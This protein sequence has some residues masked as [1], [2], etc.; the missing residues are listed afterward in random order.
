MHRSGT[1]LVTQLVNILGVDLGPESEMIRAGEENPRGF[2]ENSHIKSLNEEVLTT[3]GGSW[4]DPPNLDHGWESSENLHDLRLQACELLKRLEGDTPF[5]WKDPR[6]SLTLPFWRTVTNVEKVVVVVRDPSDVATSLKVRNGFSLSKSE[7]LWKWY[8]V[9][10]LVTAP[11]HEL[12]RYEDVLARPDETAVRLADYLGLP[13]PT[14]DVLV[15]VRELVDVQLDRAKA[16]PAERESIRVA[17]GLYDL[18]SLAPKKTY[19]AVCA[20]I[21]SGRVDQCRIQK[22]ECSAK[23]L[24]H[25]RERF[26]GEVVALQRQYA[27]LAHER[28]ELEK[29]KESLKMEGRRLEEERERLAG[30]RDQLRKALTAVANEKEAL[31]TR[32]RQAATERDNYRKKAGQ[33]ERLR[34]RR[35]VRAALFTANAAR[36]AFQVVR[37]VRDS[38]QGNV[39]GGQRSR[40][41]DS[42][43]WINLTRARKITHADV[44]RGEGYKRRCFN[45]SASDQTEQNV[46]NHAN[47]VV[48]VHNA[49]E[50]VVLCLESV[51]R[52][53]NLR[54]HKPIIVDDGSGEQT[55]AELCRRSADMGATLIRREHAGGFGVAANEG[56]ASSWL[57]AIVLLNSD[58]VVGPGWMDRLL[59]CANSDPSIGIVGP[60]SN[61]A[62]WQSIPDISDEQGSWSTNPSIEADQIT[63]I[64]RR[65]EE[66]SIRLYPKVEL[67]NGF[68]YLVTRKLLNHVG[69]LDIDTFPR[70]YGEEDDLSIRASQYGFIAAIADD[71]FVYHGKSKS[72]SLERR[73]E[74]SKVSKSA[75]H[76][77]HGDDAIASRVGRM[78]VHRDLTRART[79]ASQLVVDEG[80]SEWIENIP[81][82]GPTV[83]WIQ[84]HVRP[85]GGIRR[86][87][88][89]SNRLCR[90]G[91]WVS[92]VSLA[93]VED[94]SWANCRSDLISLDE[95]RHRH[96]DLIVV[97]DPDVLGSMDK[98]SFDRAVVYHLDA[99]FMYREKGLES[100]YGL[101]Q[102][103]PNIANSAWTAERVSEWGNVDIVAIVPGGIDTDQ[104]APRPADV[105]LDVVCYGSSRSRKRTSLIEQASEGLRVGKLVN[106][107]KNQGDL[108]WHYSRARTFV[109]ASR[110]EGFNMPCLEAMACGVPVVCTDDGGSREYVNDGENALVVAEEDPG[111][112]REGVDNLLNDEGLQCKLIANGIRT[113][114]EMSWDCAT[115]KFARAIRECGY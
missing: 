24:E 65:L 1:S 11:D 98:L 110:Q 80:G 52:H 45:V 86:A 61:A 17:R 62:S 36:P 3:M 19:V 53:T 60:W 57:P 94:G 99:Y 69:P 101:S 54:I 22:M 92:I 67:V 104:F 56:I 5:G 75:L 115:Y 93:G 59:S 72:Y 91:W 105:D 32:M 29:D 108:S 35:S 68:C 9:D 34:K 103:V 97:S 39:A 112:I 74:I 40:R 13:S 20:E 95:A 113:A 85:V 37:S 28:I 79:A 71:C 100:Y 102:E 107:S 47:I 82:Q 16:S 8:V 64:N 81:Q 27:T 96:F 48:P 7:R 70:G 51:A 63:Q 6:N 78:R 25:E 46:L 73:N 49:L 15:Q 55:R 77:K 21:A 4:D 12:I 90:A 76:E 106:L 109:S 84:P 111:A 43:G 66:K 50:D 31:K 2:W 33:F 10:A 26:R 38:R 88:E 42:R 41:V 14:Q 44:N 23:E 30:E 114:S 58:T 18:V 87:F 83:G 89:M